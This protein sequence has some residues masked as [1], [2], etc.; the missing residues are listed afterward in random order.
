[1][2]PSRRNGMIEDAFPKVGV[3]CGVCFLQKCRCTSLVYRDVI[4][5][6]PF[7]V[8]SSADRRIAYLLS[9]KSW[10]QIRAQTNAKCMRQYAHLHRSFEAYCENNTSISACG[11]VRQGVP[12]RFSADDLDFL[13]ACDRCFS[14]PR[15]SVTISIISQYAF[16]YSW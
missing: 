2:Y 14:R 1:M 15:T 11:A 8:S 6:S 4:P 16:F 13:D 12:K 10:R 7:A 5:R 9:R 3:N